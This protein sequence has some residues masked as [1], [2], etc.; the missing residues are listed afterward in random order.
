MPLAL[1]PRAAPQG[2]GYYSLESILRRRITN[3]L[4]QAMFVEGRRGLTQAEIIAACP[5]P[6]L[7][8]TDQIPVVI[9]QLL[10]DGDL[11]IRGKTISLPKKKKVARPKILANFDGGF[12]RATDCPAEVMSG[13]L[14]FL[15][16]PNL[17]HCEIASS[18]LPKACEATW[19]HLAHTEFPMTRVLDF[20]A[21]DWRR[22]YCQFAQSFVYTP[23]RAKL[24][25]VPG[26]D[27]YAIGFELWNDVPDPSLACNLSNGT[28]LLQSG[29]MEPDPESMFGVHPVGSAADDALRSVFRGMLSEELATLLSLRQRGDL[30]ARV[31]ITRR[32]G[33]DLFVIFE[34]WIFGCDPDGTDHRVPDPYALELS[35]PKDASTWQDLESSTAH[36]VGCF[37]TF[38]FTAPSP[39][40]DPESRDPDCIELNFIW[41]RFD[42]ESDEDDDPE[43]DTEVTPGECL[44]V[45]HRFAK[46]R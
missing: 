3:L 8:R 26:I 5:E 23:D 28:M 9:E 14:G 19:R 10:A 35:S 43:D 45:L 13:I 18:V 15:D 1:K 4:N 37:C 34:G 11:L 6:Y 22:I 46:F 25:P 32:G 27:A 7:H 31:A 33:A 2:G 12:R 41:R 30:W 36:S 39:G 40:V 42:E 24:P 20:D 17:L 44:Q 16:A 29:T 38:G 21:P